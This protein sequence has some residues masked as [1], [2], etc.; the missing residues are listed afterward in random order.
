MRHEPRIAEHLAKPPK[1]PERRRQ[2]DIAGEEIERL[3]Q[4]QQGDDQ[5]QR[6]T[7]RARFHI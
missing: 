4:Q 1:R 2:R 5:Q 6:I 7:P 3:P